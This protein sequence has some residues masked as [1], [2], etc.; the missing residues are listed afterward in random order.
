MRSRGHT[1]RPGAGCGVWPAAPTDDVERR[2]AARYL[3]THVLPDPDSGIRTSGE[4]RI[5]N[6]FA[7]AIGLCGNM[8][9]H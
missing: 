3:D 4:A 7:V 2:N 5:S 9:I 8:K 6:F 1:Q